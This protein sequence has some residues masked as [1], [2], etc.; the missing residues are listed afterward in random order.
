MRQV[1]NRLPNKIDKGSPNGN[2]RYNHKNPLQDFK[3]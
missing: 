2:L 1:I 3:D